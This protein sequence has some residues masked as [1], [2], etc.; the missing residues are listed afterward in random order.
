MRRA[1]AGS[2][3]PD[4]L[5]SL[6]GHRGDVGATGGRQE[7]VRGRQLAPDADDV[8]ESVVEIPGQQG[9]LH[10]V[11][12]LSFLDQGR[13]PNLHRERSGERVHLRRGSRIVTPADA[14]S[15]PTFPA[16]GERPLWTSSPLTA[17]PTVVRKTSPR[18]NGS[19]TAIPGSLPLNARAFRFAAAR[20][21][22]VA[23]RRAK[24]MAR[25]EVFIAFKMP[26]PNFPFD[27]HFAVR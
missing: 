18:S 9:D 26:S 6:E 4:K 17:L 3:L 20:R 24:S 25:I 12:E 23:P 7:R 5:E 19:S 21:A 16:H 13:V 22:T 10:V 14:I 2:R 1:D 15:S 11:R 27:P 8:L